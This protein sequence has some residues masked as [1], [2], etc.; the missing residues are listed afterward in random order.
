ML[1]DRPY[2]EAR[3]E[4]DAVDEVMRAAGTQFDPACVRAFAELVGSAPSRSTT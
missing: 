3:P 1:E 2:R 4:P